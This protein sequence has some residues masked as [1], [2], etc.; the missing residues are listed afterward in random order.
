MKRRAQASN[1][2]WK[3][4]V[5]TGLRQQPRITCTRMAED[6]H[7]RVLREFRPCRLRVHAAAGCGRTGKLSRSGSP[8]VTGERAR[9][10]SSCASSGWALV[11]V[12]CSARDCRVTP[13]GRKTKSILSHRSYR[14]SDVSCVRPLLS[15]LLF[16]YVLTLW[17]AGH[18]PCSLGSPSTAPGN[19]R[20][21]ACQQNCEAGNLGL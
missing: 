7:G 8:S 18:L 5:R 2:P 15:Q 21:Q 12:T 20:R 9:L 4:L 13:R 10:T 3:V 17:Q 6:S 19:I 1:R 11:S 14:V 16:S